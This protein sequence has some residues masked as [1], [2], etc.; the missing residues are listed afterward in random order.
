MFM[1]NILCMADARIKDSLMALVDRNIISVDY[2]LA[3]V[4]HSKLQSLSGS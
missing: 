2:C 4:N 3:S 1:G